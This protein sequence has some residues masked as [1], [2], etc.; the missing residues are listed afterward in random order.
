M[1]YPDPG[2]RS[3]IAE[4]VIQMPYLPDTLVPEQ[5][6]WPVVTPSSPLRLRRIAERMG[7]QFTYET[8]FDAVYS[9]AAPEPGVVLLPSCR[10][11]LVQARLIAGGIGIGDAADGPVATW[12]YVHPYE[13]GC[14]LIAEAWPFVM[15]T[16]PGIR[17]RGPF[18][19]AGAALRDRLEGHRK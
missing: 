15:R 10:R 5:E 8:R 13:R 3:V 9:A 14:G 16:W 2:A 11:H 18:T 17:L 1:N 19:P 6:L 7:R 4:A 12:I